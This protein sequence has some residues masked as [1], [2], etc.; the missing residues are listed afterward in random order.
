MTFAIRRLSPLDGTFFPFSRHNKKGP[1]STLMAGEIPPPPSP[2]MAN[3]MKIPPFLSPSLIISLVIY[4]CTPSSAP[5]SHSRE[6]SRERSVYKYLQKYFC[7][8]L[9]SQ[10]IKEWN[11]SPASVS[12]WQC[13][14][15][16]DHLQALRKD[17]E[18]CVVRPRGLQPR[19]GSSSVERK[20]CE[21]RAF[22]DQH[23]PLQPEGWR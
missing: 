20:R 10:A 1:I 2:L 5:P 11:C 15:L 12:S 13:S 9:Q 7:T 17:V 6:F 21:G 8:C 18:V 19:P 22:P 3:V 23:V 4:Y 16:F 14:C